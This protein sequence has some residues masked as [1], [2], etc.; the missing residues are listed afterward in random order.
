M[1]QM[2]E[3]LPYIV[4]E[5]GIFGKATWWQ[6]LLAVAIG[7]IVTY[8]AIMLFGLLIL[9]NMWAFLILVGI[10]ALLAFYYEVELWYI[11]GLIMGLVFF[12]VHI[13]LAVFQFTQFPFPIFG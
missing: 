10:P 1:I 3:V 11:V 9:I 6:R 2:S 7:I 8:G 4:V 5:R 13:L 12:I